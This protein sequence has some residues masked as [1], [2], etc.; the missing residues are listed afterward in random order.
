MWLYDGSPMVLPC[1]IILGSLQLFK[2]G[3]SRAGADRV[4]KDILVGSHGG[5]DRNVVVVCE[6]SQKLMA[7]GART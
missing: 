1:C 7:D 2:R 6:V 5:V 4:Q 3:G